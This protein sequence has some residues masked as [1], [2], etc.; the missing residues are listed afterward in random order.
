MLRVVVVDDS[1]AMRISVG[2]MLKELGFEVFEAASAEAALAV[3]DAI[4]G[5]KPDLFV[6]DLNMPGMDGIALTRH[7]RARAEHRFTPVLLL[8]KETA[9]ARRDEA[10]TAGASGWLVKPVTPADLL[11]VVRQVCPK[12]A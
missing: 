1:S 6:L 10:R 5:P 9:Q 4:E 7:V 12:A 3:L 8:T 11:R 2:L